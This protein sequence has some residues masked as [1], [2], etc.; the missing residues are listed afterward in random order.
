MKAI[1]PEQFEILDRPFVDIAPIALNGLWRVYENI[2]IS[3]NLGIRASKQTLGR[4]HFN[5]DDNNHLLGTELL[6]EYPISY[7]I[8]S[9]QR[10]GRLVISD[11]TRFRVC[12]TP[13]TCLEKIDSVAK[14]CL[15]EE[16]DI[17]VAI[18]NDKKHSTGPLLI[19]KSLVAIPKVE[20]PDDL[21]AIYGTYSED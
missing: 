16:N 12:Y 21:F 18:D 9:A 8:E 6:D 2:W 5:Y 17:F 11:L 1:S 10:I 14:N 20:T 4:L 15:D 13:E 7:N 19:K 3:D